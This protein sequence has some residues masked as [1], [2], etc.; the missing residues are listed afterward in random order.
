MPRHYSMQVFLRDKITERATQIDDGKIN[1]YRTIEPYP[2]ISLNFKFDPKLLKE[3]T[4]QLVFVI[5]FA[6][7][8]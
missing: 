2:H 5:S 4:N 8:Q 7:E 3:D 1:N 6:P